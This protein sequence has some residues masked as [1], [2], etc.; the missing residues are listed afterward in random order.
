MQH[1]WNYADGKTEV[2]FDYLSLHL[3]WTSLRSNPDLQS[4]RPVTAWH[5]PFNDSDVYEQLLLAFKQEWVI[6]N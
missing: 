6:V 3:K 4:E 5:G 2:L 1:R